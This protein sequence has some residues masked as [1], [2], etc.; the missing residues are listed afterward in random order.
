MNSPSNG[1]YSKPEAHVQRGRAPAAAWVSWTPSGFS[2]PLVACDLD[3][4]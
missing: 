2:K 4:I 1:L 3:V